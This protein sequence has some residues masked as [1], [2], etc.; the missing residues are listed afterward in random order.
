MVC[1]G[2]CEVCEVSGV[3]EVCVVCEGVCERDGCVRC[4]WYVRVCVIMRYCYTELCS[5]HFVFQRLGTYDL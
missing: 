1:E 5:H 4:V 2:V 3:C